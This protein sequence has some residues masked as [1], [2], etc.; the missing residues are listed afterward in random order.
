MSSQFKTS[1]SARTI[2]S[3][4]PS[5][6]GLSPITK[7][8]RPAILAV[9]FDDRLLDLGI[10][11]AMALHLFESGQ[12]TLSQSA[13]VGICRSKI[14][15]TCWDRRESPP[16]TIPPMNWSESLR[17]LEPV[18]DLI[19]A[20]AGPLIGM[21]RIGLLSL[22]RDLY[23]KVVVPPKVYDELQISLLRPWRPGLGGRLQ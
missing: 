2:C 11:R 5:R 10:H 14:S 3:A 20:D 7:D 23:S 8:G 6:A 17:R 21:A 18:S 19:V 22:L 4:M 13:K 15:L 12:A 16:S 1:L 9:P